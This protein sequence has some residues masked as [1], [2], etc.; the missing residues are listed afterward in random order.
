[1]HTSYTSEY[2]SSI[3]PVLHWLQFS[4]PTPP[5][6][7]LKSPD[8][9]TK[10]DNGEDDENLNFSFRVEEKNLCVLPLSQNYLN[11]LIKDRGLIKSNFE[12]LKS[13]VK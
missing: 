11:D 4:I 6:K 13:S 2:T 3:V 12:F 5:K 1:M 8:D 7:M 9:C 10:S